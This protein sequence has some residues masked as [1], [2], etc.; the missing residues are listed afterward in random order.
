MPSHKQS[1]ADI[2]GTFT[3]L[4]PG[5]ELHLLGIPSLCSTADQLSLK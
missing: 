2:F 3:L 5:L 4:L 1:E